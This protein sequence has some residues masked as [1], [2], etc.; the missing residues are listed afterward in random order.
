MDNKKEFQRFLTAVGYAIGLIVTIACAAGCISFGATKP[1]SFY[2]VV[3]ILGLL[4]WGY[5]LV[6]NFIKFYKTTKTE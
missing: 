1:E 5:V 4:G 6:K 3:G 2:I